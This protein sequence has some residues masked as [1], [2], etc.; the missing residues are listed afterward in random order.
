MKKYIRSILQVI[1]FAGLG[2][3]ILVWMFRRQQEKFSL[4]C[5][6]DNIPA[7]ECSLM[8]KILTDFSSVNIGILCIVIFLFVLSNVSRAIRWNMLIEPLGHKPHFINTMGTILVGYFANLGLPRSGE[9]IRAASLARYEGL[10]FVKVMGTVVTDRIMDLICLMS[11]IA[12][13]FILEFSTVK[14]WVFANI[15][16]PSSAGV[17]TFIVVV[18][19][20]MIALIVSVFI[21]NRKAADSPIIAKTKRILQGFAEGIGSVTRVKKPFWFI[22]H[23]LNI[24]VMFFLMTYVAFFAF[25]PASHLD[26]RAGLMIFVFGSLGIVFP[27]PGGMGAFHFLATT[28]L[29][30]YGIDGSDAFSMANILYFTLQIFGNVLFGI[31]ALIVLYLFNRSRTKTV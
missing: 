18:L 7:E 12:L 29:E 27:S 5:A 9:V 16:I 25:E 1:L 20:T 14:D 30:I 11:I 19:I 23:S 24:W 31:I 13:A 17:T 6:L 22:V 15:N 28:A 10:P 8:D 2:L 4:Q 26:I 21:L 3:G